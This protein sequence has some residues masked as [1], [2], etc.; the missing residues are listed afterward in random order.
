MLV[1]HEE[2]IRLLQKTIRAVMVRAETREEV[3]RCE[4]DSGGDRTRDRQS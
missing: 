1:D 3:R 2:E 4:K